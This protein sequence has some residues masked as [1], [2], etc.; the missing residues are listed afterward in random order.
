[1]TVRK[2]PRPINSILIKIKKLNIRGG[3]ALARL[4]P[5]KE[6]TLDEYFR[7]A[8][9]ER[10]ELYDG[11]PV[12]MSPA[13]S[14]HEG[15]VANVSF[16][17]MSGLKGS[18]YQTYGSNL[19]VVV[20]TGK[21]GKPKCYLPDLT[22]ICD[23]NKLRDGKCYGAPDLVVEVLSKSTAGNDL[24]TKFND[25]QNLGVLEYWVVDY[26]NFC[27]YRYTL[28]GTTFSFPKIF[29]LGQEVVSAIFPDVRFPL[30]SIFRHIPE[31][32]QEEF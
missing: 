26:K 32:T 28:E 23:P 4:D 12:L 25:Y 15:T 2:V 5:N 19:A 13:H 29:V 10:Y 3:I 14:D 6:Y 30:H 31:S 27:L 1:M 18:S 8:G 24:I 20:S 22:V 21:K 7:Y 9:D 16:E 17:I 11:F